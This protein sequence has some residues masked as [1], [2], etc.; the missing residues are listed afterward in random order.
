VALADIISKIRSDAELEAA[1]LLDSAQRRA[2]TIDAAAR[3][4]ADGHRKA[5]LA[6]AESDARREAD[7]IV[8]SARLVARDAALTQ[9][10]TLVD[11]VLQLTTGALAAAP[12]AE[13]ATFLARRIAEVARG[14]EVLRFGAA[15]LARA[16]SIVE[17]LRMIA[18]GLDLSVASDAA[19]FERGALIE[20]DRVRADLSL[21]AIVEERRDELELVVATALFTEEA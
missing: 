8:V 19:P 11:E 3:A 14:G 12:D 7:R 9:R 1:Q 10:R 16:D 21:A 20:G 17:A 2:D 13:Y 4:D 15:D 6:R 18:P 5:V